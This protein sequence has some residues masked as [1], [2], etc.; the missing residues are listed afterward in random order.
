MK[1]RHI[2]ALAI[3]VLLVVF[4]LQ[5]TTDV[6]IRFLFWSLGMSRA[7]MVILLIAAGVVIGWAASSRSKRGRDRG[8]GKP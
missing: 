2:L 1:Y 6:E 3:T 5:N 4:I 7:L 8:E